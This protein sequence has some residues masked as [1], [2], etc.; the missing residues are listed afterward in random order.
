MTSLVVIP[1]AAAPPAMSCS[2]DDWLRGRVASVNDRLE[3]TLTDGTNLK[4]A[5]ID[6]PVPTPN[7]PELDAEA[8]AKLAAW[9]DGREVLFRPVGE[10]VD[11]WG[12]TVALVSAPTQTTTIAVGEALLDAGLARFG[13]GPGTGPCRRQF[14]AAEARARD[15]GLGLW[16]D[17]YY[18]VLS[19]TDRGAFDERSATNV[20]VEGV[21]TS[22]EENRFRTDLRFGGRRGYDFSVTVLPRHRKRFEAEGI[23]L[24]ELEG[25]NLRVRGLLDLRFGPRIEISSPDEIEVLGDG[26]R[27]GGTA[28]A[29]RDHIPA[30]ADRH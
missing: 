17:P 23:A 7:D 14:L 20:V 30:S 2:P 16:A 11:R 19:A 1:A 28:A 13:P 8:S 22:V 3:L 4:I 21:V 9:L 12:R 27:L 18:A 6:P 5:G 25:R 29:T 15:E 26:S 10:R 24:R